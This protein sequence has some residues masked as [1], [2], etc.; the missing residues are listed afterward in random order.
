MLN[1]FMR[2]RTIIKTGGLIMKRLVVSMLTVFVLTILLTNVSHAINI[3]LRVVVD[4]EEVNFPDA[5]PFID[6]NGRTQTPSRF[7]GEAIGAT[8]TWDGNAKKAV[9]KMGGTTLEL[10]IGKKEYQ[11]DG[12]KSKWTQRHC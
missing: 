9:F 3:P 7:I 2:A 4:G 12:Q 6:A 5:Q 8:V 1:A 10:F 11:L